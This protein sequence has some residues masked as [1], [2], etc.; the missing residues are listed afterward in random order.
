[1]KKMQKFYHILNQ[2][3]SLSSDNIILCNEFHQDYA[4]FES[5]D[6]RER[7]C[8]IKI[9]VMNDLLTINDNCIDIS[10][11]PTPSHFIF[12]I[13]VS[14]IM[15]RL[16][17]FYL[18]HAGVLQYRDHL[19][20]LAGSP[21][22]GKST[23]VN[24]FVEKGSTFFSD[25]CAPL[26]KQTGLIYPFPRSM[27]MIDSSQEP[28]HVFRLKKSIPIVAPGKK[29]VKPTI[30]IC[31]TDDT[32]QDRIELNLSLKILS[33]SLMMDLQA[34]EGLVINRRHDYYEEYRIS[35]QASESIHERIQQVFQKHRQ[36]LWH[37]YRVAPERKCFHRPATITEVTAHQAAAHMIPEMKL[38]SSHLKQS[39]EEPKM[40]SL[41]HISKLIQDVR[42]FFMSVGHLASEIN[43]IEQIL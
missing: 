28:L 4:F 12:Q 2:A 9:Q 22:I 8:N 26:H 19:I 38:F 33:K 39:S 40:I 23:L 20:V 15:S 37:V 36:D 17:G 18:L 25:D 30:I 1:M 42:C 41:I 5:P 16:T 29:P 35:Y 21:G 14:E 7:A 34:L 43:C 6:L 3:I 11:H 31:L 27:W 24:A 13:I 10:S 32:A